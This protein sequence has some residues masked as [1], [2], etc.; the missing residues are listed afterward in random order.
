[1][2]AIGADLFKRDVVSLFDFLGDLRIALSMCGSRETFAVFDRKD[3]VVVGIVCTVVGVYDAHAGS[4]S[5]NRTFNPPQGARYGYANETGEKFE[6]EFLM[7][8]AYMPLSY[9]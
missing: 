7:D 3:D 6:W 4:I 1:M 2:V 8:R 9:S 5:E